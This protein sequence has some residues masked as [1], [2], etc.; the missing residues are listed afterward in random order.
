MRLNEVEQGAEIMTRLHIWQCRTRKHP[1]W[2]PKGAG[3]IYLSAGGCS[4]RVLAKN[5]TDLVKLQQR[6]F[7]CNCLMRQ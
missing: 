1:Y 3:G 7:F 6:H 4:A 2:Q 5:M